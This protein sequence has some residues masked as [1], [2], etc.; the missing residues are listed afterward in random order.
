MENSNRFLYVIAAFVVVVG[1]GLAIII[2][3]RRASEQPFV[4]ETI[5][6]PSSSSK[7][8]PVAAGPKAANFKLESLDG[9]TVTLDQFAGKVVFLNIWATWCG[10][11]REEMPSMETLYN[12]FMT[13]KDFVMLAVSQ[14]ERGRT[15]VA[16]Y[17][18]K[19]GYHFTVLLD[20][21]NKVS[22]S[23]DVSG[24]PE[25]FIIDRNGR[26]VAHHMGG[27]DWSRPDVK[28]ALQQLLDAKQG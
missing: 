18:A 27:F 13:N 6:A 26:I 23:Y 9:A 16:P 28:D 21:E 15:A 3:N 20:P 7:D 12:E 2:E 5:P 11:C 4:G 19:N 10:P 14:D 22:T 25:T 1:L 24:V 17:V 8:E